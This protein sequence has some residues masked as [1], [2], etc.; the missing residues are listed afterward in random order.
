SAALVYN[1][2]TVA[3]QPVVQAAIPTAAGEPLPT[4]ITVQLTFNG[5]IQ[6]AQTY[7]VPNNIQPG[8]TLN[9]AAQ[10][11][12]PVSQTGRYGYALNVTLNYPNGMGSLSRTFT[13][14]TFE[15]VSESP[16]GRGW[17]LSITDQLIPIAADAN[18]PAGVLRVYGSGGYRFYQSTG[19]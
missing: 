3:V 18:G 2:D 8:D 7:N 15:V 6:P 4:S 11:A 13:G 17:S 14:S 9:V 19:N 1:S 5:V 16:L 12:N 10:V